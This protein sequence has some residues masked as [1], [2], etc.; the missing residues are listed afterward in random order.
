MLRSSL[1]LS[2][3]NILASASSY[4]L[5][6]FLMKVFNLDDF[7]YYSYVLVFSSFYSILIVFAT[8]Q[9]ASRKFFKLNRSF[10]VIKEVV[11]FRVLML[12]FGVVIISF[13]YD[14][15]FIIGFIAFCLPSLN[16]SYGYEVCARNFKYS[17]VFLCERLIYTF[18]VFLI[19]TFFEPRLFILFY[20]LIVVSLLSFT[21][22]LHDLGLCF[23]F[24][25]KSIKSSL[26]VFG[27]NFSLMFA[28]LALFSYGGFSRI[29][30]EYNSGYSTLAVYSAAW[31][32]VMLGTLFQTQVERIFRPRISN[33]EDVLNNF[34]A[35]IKIYFYNA[36]LPM[37]ICSV[38]V[39]VFGSDLFFLIFG[40]KYI[41]S[42]Y[43]IKIFA[44]YFMVISIDSL[45]RMIYLK[46]DFDNIY[47]NIQVV[48][49]LTLL[50]LLLLIGDTKVEFFALLVCIVHASATAM[51]LMFIIFF[52]RKIFNET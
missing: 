8:D 35:L 21:Y 50:L 18:A 9:T 15:K 48:F 11:L 7:G 5:T 19:F 38:F 49:A 33:S 30:L 22:Q 14:F 2:V 27:E 42:A 51:S 45:V 37:L 16:V 25:I 1:S 23:K 32:F 13:F 3:I 24:S 4:A 28:T 40:D 34:R 26:N 43:L 52:N 10:N 44:V 29:I 46:L 12:F 39:F 31:Q 17:I 41:A 20:V 6:I 36:F 47:R